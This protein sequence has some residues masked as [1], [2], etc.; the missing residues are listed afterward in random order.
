MPRPLAYVRAAAAAVVVA[1]SSFASAAV[2]VIN[3]F[4][5]AAPGTVAYGFQRPSFSGTTDDNL[6][7]FG[8]TITPNVQTATDAFPAGNPNAG[9]RVGQAQFQ[10][11]DTATN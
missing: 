7:G 3:N 11:I 9:S 5:G 8:A 4:E 2:T 10:F 1:A 6:N